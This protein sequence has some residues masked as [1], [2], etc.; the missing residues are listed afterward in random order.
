MKSKII[1][2]LIAL[3]VLAFSAQA[4]AQTKDVALIYGAETQTTDVT[5]PVW[6]ETILVQLNS[7]LV[8]PTLSWTEAEWDLILG[9]FKI[10]DGATL[11]PVTAAEISAVGTNYISLAFNASVYHFGPDK[12]DLKLHYVNYSGIAITTDYGNLQNTSTAVNIDDGIDPIL[13]TYSIQSNNSGNTYLG[14]AGNVVTF[15][16]EADEALANTPDAPIVTFTVPEL[17]QTF[18]VNAETV[19]PLKKEWTASFTIP[20]PGSNL[21]GRVSVSATFWDV[22]AN[23]GSLS[24]AVDVGTDDTYVI[25]KNY[26]P[27]TVYVNETWASQADVTPGLIW[28]W[29][30]FAVVQ[31]GIDGVTDDGTGIVNV[32]TGTYNEDLTIGK[33]IELKP[34]GTAKAYDV[35]TLKGVATVAAGL[36]PLAD[37][38]I[39]I[40]ATGVSIH[41]FKIEAPDYVVGFYSSGIV[42]GATN[43]AI[44]NNA[45]YANRVNSTDDISQSI[46]TYATVDI[47]GLGIFTNTFNNKVDKIAFWGYE[48]IYINAGGTGNVNIED[49][50]F[51]D[52][53]FRGITTQRSNV[54]IE[55][56]NINTS[57]APVS[58]DWMTVGSWVGIWA[59]DDISGVVITGN[60]VQGNV[61]GA[62]FNRGIRLGST[63]GS[64]FTNLSVTSNEIYYN[65]NGIYS[66]SATGI[67][68]TGNAIE[69]NTAYGIFCD[70][71]TLN[72]E[73][74]WWGSANGPE[75]SGNVFNVGDQGDA[76]SDNVDYVPWYD[77]DMTHT[78]YAP[79][80]MVDAKATTYYS[81]INAAVDA[82][83]GGETITC[84]AGTYTQTSSVTYPISIDV[85]NLTLKGA[86]YNVDPT[87]GG[88]TVEALESV[89]DA[90]GT[91]GQTNAIEVV[92]GTSGITIN[93]FTV[94]NTINKAI[95]IDNSTYVVG[96]IIKT[97]LMNVSYNILYNNL[98]GIVAYHNDTS[99]FSYNYIYSNT[100]AFY[101]GIVA[102]NTIVNNNLITNNTPSTPWGAIMVSL[103]G[104][105]Y[106]A[107]QPTITSNIITNNGDIGITVYNAS[108]IIQGNT[109]TGHSTCGIYVCN[110][111]YDNMPTTLI[112]SANTITGNGTVP[113]DLNAGIMVVEAAPEIDGNTI[114]NNESYGIK[115]RGTHNPFEW[116]TDVD[117]VIN[118]N[119]ISDNTV[120]GMYFRST[121]KHDGNGD[122]K[123]YCSPPITNNTITGNVSRGILIDEVD[124]AWSGPAYYAPCDPTIHY[125]NISNNHGLIKPSVA[126][127]G[128]EVK[129]PGAYVDAEN[130]WWGSANGP[131]HVDNTFNVGNQGDE[132][133]DYVDYVTWYDADMT[134]SSFAPVRL[135]QMFKVDDPYLYFSSI[136]TAIDAA[137]LGDEIFCYAGTFTEDFI[138]DVGVS[139]A[140]EN[141]KQAVTLLGEQEVTASNVSFYLFEFDTDGA[142][143]AILV[144]SSGA[145][146]DNFDVTYCD[147]T[148][149]TSPSVGIYL[150]GGSSPQAISDVDIK[151]N[152]FNGPDDKA[153]NP[154]K[155][156]GSFGNNIS[157]AVTDLEFSTNEVNK[158]S[159]PVNLVD[160]D[161]DGL[162]ISYNDFFDTDGVIYFWNDSGTPPTGELSD[163]QFMNNYIPDSNSYGV[164]IGGA[165][166]G[167]PIFTDL[168]FGS[169]NKIYQNA[170]EMVGVAYTYYG[171]VYM[172]DQYTGLLDASDN[173]W[174]Y[175]YG[176]VNNNSTYTPPETD[177]GT[178]AT[179][180]D[181]VEFAP[182]YNLGTDAWAGRGWEPDASAEEFAPVINVTHTSYHSSIQRAIDAAVSD[183]EIACIAGTFTEDFSIPAATTGIELRPWEDPIMKVYDDVTIKGVATNHW[184]NPGGWP[185]AVPNIEILADETYI[186]HFTIESPDVPDEYYSSGMVIDGEDIEICYNEFV[187][188]GIGEVDPG[189]G[190]ILQTYRDAVLG[191]D[192]N[193]SGL[194]IHHNDFSGEPLGSYVGIFINHQGV[195]VAELD[196]VDIMNNTFDGYCY[197]GIVTERDWTGI[198]FNDVSRSYTPT[199]DGMN[200]GIAK[201]LKMD[202]TQPNK[203]TSLAGYG[204]IVQ[205]WSDRAQSH[206][207]VEENTID[208]FNFGILVG[209][210][211]DV[212]DLTDISIK[213]N[214]ITENDTGIYVRSDPAA[215]EV[216]YNSIAGN[217][218]YGLNNGV[219]GTEVPATK[220][221]WGDATGPVNSSNPHSPKGYGD[222][223]NV[224][225]DVDF[226]PWYATS[227]VT[228]TTEYVMTHSEII[229]KGMDEALAYADAIQP[230]IDATA[231]IYTYVQVSDDDSPYDEDLVVDRTAYIYGEGLLKVGPGVQITGTHEVT[232]NNVTFDY[233]TL[234]PGSGVSGTVIT[235]NSASQII[236]NTTIVNCIFNIQTSPSIGVYVGGAT[237]TN[238]VNSTLFLGN[239]FNGP[240]DMISNPFK[241]GGDFGNPVGCEIGG[242]DFSYN[243]V[244]YGSIPIN[245]ADKNVDLT[246]QYNTFANTDGVIYFWGE[247]VVK[248]PTGVIS[249]L[250]FHNNY[251]DDTNSY[252]V[253]F[254]VFGN[255]T[256]ANYGGD[257]HL[258]ENYFDEDIP[259]AY[260][261][262]AV[263]ILTPTV[264]LAGY[265]IDAASNWW[266]S[267]DGPSHSSNTFN[268]PTQGVA[269]SDN[270]DF[271]RWYDSGDNDGADPGW[272]PDG[273]LFAPVTTEV[274]GSNGYASI[275]A[276]ID[277]S[278]SGFSI[279]CHGAPSN[280]TGTFYED[281]SVPASKANLYIYPYDPDKIINDVTIKGQATVEASLFPLADP[282]IE[283]LGNGTKLEGFTIEAPEYVEGYYSS[284]IVVGAL[285]V[286]IYSNDFV[287]NTVNTT[288]DISQA[289]QNY[290][291]VDCST[292]D[293]RYN[294]FNDNLAKGSW[295]YEAIYINPNTG[296][297]WI[298]DNTFT[299]MCLRAIT[300]DDNDAMQTIYNNT[301]ETTMIPWVDWST[302]GAYQGINLVGDLG[303]VFVQ[304]NYI[305]G[306]SSSYGFAQGIRVGYDNEDTFT[307]ISIGYTDNTRPN[308]ISYNTYGILVKSATNVAINYNIIDGNTY[309]VQNDDTGAKAVLDA[310]YNYWGATDGPSFTFDYGIGSGSGDEVSEYVDFNPWYEDDAL[311]T[312]YTVTMAQFLLQINPTSPYVDNYFDLRVCAADAN[313]IRDFS[314]DNLADFSSSHV[315][316]S[317]PEEQLLVD[318]FKE[319][320]GACISDLPFDAADHLTIYAWEYDTN[321]PDYYSNLTDIVIQ[322]LNDPAPPTGVVFT[323]NPDDN[324]GWILVDYT[325]S[326]DD[327]FYT[328]VKDTAYGVSYYVVEIFM[329]SV[330]GGQWDFLADIACYDNGTGTNTYTALLPAPASD[331]PY[332]F[333]MASV[334]NPT[335]VGGFDENHISYNEIVTKDAGAQSAW[336]TGSAAPKDNLPAYAD[337][338][339]FLQGAYLNGVMVDGAQKP[340]TSP[341]DGQTI[342]ALP[343][344]NDQIIDWVYVEL[345]LAATGETVKEANAFLLTDGTLVDVDGNSS[346]PFFY[347]TDVEYYM[348]IHH[349]NHIDIMSALTHTFGDF[350]SQATTIDLTGSTAAYG[351]GFADLG[352][353]DYGLYGG[354]VNNNNSVTIGDAIETYNHRG[355]T[356]YLVWD[357]NMNGSVTIGDAISCY[358]NRGKATTVPNQ[359]AKD[360]GHPLDEEITA[361]SSK[362]NT[363]DLQISNP[364]LDGGM[365][366]MEV[367]LRRTSEW[368]FIVPSIGYDNLL[369][370]ADFQFDY[371]PAGFTGVPTYSNL[372]AGLDTAEY[373]T[374]ISVAA[375]ALTL[376]ITG[377]NPVTPTMYSPALNVWETIC[378]IE[379]TI[380]DIHENSGVV[381]NESGTG[382]ISAASFPSGLLTNSYF[383]SGDITLPVELSEFK[384]MFSS[385]NEN[386]ELR[387]D[388]ATE[389]DVNGFNIYRA[390]VKDL[391]RAGRHI[392]YSLIPA[393]GTT[394]EP[395][396]YVY[397][398]VVADVYAT[399]YYWLE[400]VDFGGTSSFHGPY[401]YTPGDIDGDS[402]PDLIASTEL[403]GNFPNP[404]IN[405]TKIKYQ[406]KGTVIDQNTTISV[407]NVRGELVTTLQGRNGVATLDTSNM[408]HGIYFYRLQTDDYSD[409]K[410]LIVVK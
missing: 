242:L 65:K 137:V 364:R 129:D 268:V 258:Y 250:D 341:Y 75:H 405:S 391:T 107:T 229:T 58:D 100:L 42:V 221:W 346:L 240:A 163:F 315:A 200:A 369:Q 178:A 174:G 349:T 11:V 45:F 135:H 145:P 330:S 215:L 19:D 265:V 47:S 92:T 310:T 238:A 173:W 55:G 152:K 325:L 109:V 157:C 397:G 324:G 293:I 102:S 345:R 108:A 84:A 196:D 211:G 294:T 230:C 114:S 334:Y 201:H 131:V 348:V 313:G 154:W 329:P 311:T 373:T 210:N 160:E 360:G 185:L 209:R 194:Y 118:N 148:L 261:F 358:D 22:H 278:S 104:N 217:V 279:V 362:A 142:G 379:L 246:V 76:S 77:T 218:T 30:A 354:D 27:A 117:A 51:N 403:L 257:I 226:I 46:Q 171:A 408:G 105:V 110:Q 166:L 90:A 93:G 270:V 115:L 359:T 399:H 245:I 156:G 195:A 356:G 224:S 103:G 378:T 344:P 120:A 113:H 269:V 308:E 380:A 291:D 350:A 280:A 333:R 9:D 343:L 64:T 227:T 301:I 72:A 101:L 244:N 305:G 219:A 328:A 132:V 158:G 361:T 106:P 233:L 116:G 395:Q 57:Q 149:T 394:T 16:F 339:I 54:T 283:I 35:V 182:W 377:P 192:S 24:P 78:S 89:V 79:V 249:E 63:G 237:P 266:G 73:N 180:S 275:Q 29:D 43:A 314:Y 400:V 410:K 95:Q 336:Q 56:N 319:V 199:K 389:N 372:N 48:G 31:D 234:T 125:N 288:G 316:L 20:D 326:I 351:G 376:S 136:Q 231:T 159:I 168:N 381:W 286:F 256:S 327:P 255:F 353:D 153:C 179:V 384:A 304:D 147:F 28:Q 112:N 374:E 368:P 17:K 91:I 7:D 223:D 239:T 402:T 263:S 141:V 367:Q 392:N 3:F 23:S 272:D 169:G 407:Y 285:G 81:S 133:S 26:D 276:A 318:G 357:F 409:I 352:N 170:F 248:S 207:T 121:G 130:N 183:D 36:F 80:V 390:D 236:A 68:I 282:N 88:R 366:K 206:V 320:T 96:D 40:Q 175:E 144:N 259:G 123:L 50:T 49:N 307:N 302:S 243:Y 317:V 386:I 290:N 162:Y 309:G 33:S 253:G 202:I 5:D 62:G 12:N 323:D 177:V 189:G 340:L 289:I 21:D 60:T 208:N 15:T 274:K 6:A 38:N 406:I 66:Q 176:P 214:D 273:E 67:T 122:H 172:A 393:A 271:L 321:P 14:E 140:G 87:Q 300:V 404:A 281:F 146:I 111:P 388:T 69:N 284:G 383:G 190:V 197:Q 25:V 186:H 10:L 347:T 262:G 396:S 331:T 8:D 39:D 387:W 37:P 260:G 332:S 287:M 322:E 165:S 277:A 375:N 267:E 363:V 4:V 71:G 235:I 151:N 365:F 298:E 99:V 34:Y 222:G 167:G 203:G 2:L 370:D 382:L 241:V 338:K 295:G 52:A 398:D 181:R 128:L 59:W 299:G 119:T 134:G 342:T 198:Y 161:I 335:K 74:N 216:F 337:M 220:N 184:A 70:T 32:H 212:Q 296:V 205:D 228:T 292:L 312:L 188:Y 138:V 150:G 13:Y 193:I 187:I 143:T 18:V 191:Y 127:Y 371:N 41:H 85:D 247:D 155:I 97:H 44:Y 126:G 1:I 401:A 232:A 86:Q 83:V 61:G 254:D 297:T 225:D 252:G 204:I 164:A 53:C 124:P 139:L 355:E 94:K 98:R 306:T 82:A 251:I 385:A 264:D 213:Y 303:T